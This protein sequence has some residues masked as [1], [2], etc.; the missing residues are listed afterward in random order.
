MLTVRMYTVEIQ[1]CKW[2]VSNFM[3]KLILQY[4]VVVLILFIYLYLRIHF[5]G[6]VGNYCSK[7]N[8]FY[9]NATITNFFN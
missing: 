9:Y 8:N 2:L 3:I 6:H 1:Q 5:P 7:Y 4:S